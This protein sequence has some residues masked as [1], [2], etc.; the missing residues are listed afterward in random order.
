MSAQIPNIESIYDY[1]S[2]VV[3]IYQ[4]TASSIIFALHS[5]IGET[6][7]GLNHVP[8]PGYNITLSISR[9]RKSN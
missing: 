2:Q 6:M 7:P 3:I 4:A 1:N 8:R 9:R 5:N